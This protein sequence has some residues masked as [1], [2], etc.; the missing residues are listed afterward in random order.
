MVD[1][2]FSKNGRRGWFRHL[3]CLGKQTKN[4]TGF[5][6]LSKININV[7]IFSPGNL[8]SLVLK[9]SG[10]KDLSLANEGKPRQVRNK[11]LPEFCTKLDKI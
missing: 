3:A 11:K 8:L 7:K 6:A 9:Y 2:P 10:I 4:Q 1:S 5:V